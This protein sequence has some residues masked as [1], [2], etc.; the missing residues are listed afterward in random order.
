MDDILWVVPNLDEDFKIIKKNINLIK[1]FSE[2]NKYSFSVAIMDGGSSYSLLKNLKELTTDKIFLFSVL[3][4]VRPTKNKGIKDALDFFESKAVC[5]VDADCSN[6][7]EDV[8][9]QLTNPVLKRN[10]DLSLPYVTKS[11]GRINRLV[12]NPL[13]SLL[14]KDVRKK[15]KFPLSGIVSLKYKLLKKIV[16]KK[17]YLWDWGGEIQIIIYAARNSKK[18]NQ[19]HFNKIDAKKRSMQSKRLD[20]VHITRAI[21]YE[22]L[23]KS[24]SY[25]KKQFKDVNYTFTEFENY[26]ITE[27][28][29][30]VFDEVFL[31]KKFDRK[32]MK[33]IS[34]GKID[35]LNFDK[36][37]EVVCRIYE[38]KLL[39]NLNKEWIGIFTKRVLALIN[40]QN[41]FSNAKSLNISN[42]SDK[43]LFKLERI[44]NNNGS[45][46]NK[47]KNILKII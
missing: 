47:T 40:Y 45:N 12:C 32:V 3:P 30:N 16:N 10:Y 18:I 20:A 2:K 8:L 4:T 39:N 19:F 29:S 28:V 31:D 42:L 35:F 46:H 34:T 38:E 22:Y 7:T 36:A 43:Q 24:K 27:L 17:D 33:N 13:L 1:S 9:K 14:F 15:I 6:L 11:G 37:E 25:S 41:S 44:Y 26:C 5:I 21:L 23:R